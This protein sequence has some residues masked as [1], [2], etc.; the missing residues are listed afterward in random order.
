MIMKYVLIAIL[1]IAGMNSMA[2]NVKTLGAKGD[3]KQDD[4]PFI[5]AAIERALLL[6]EDLFLPAGVY[7]CDAFT[8]YDK[9]IKMNQYGTKKIKIYGEAGTKITTSKSSGC[10]FYIYYKSADVVIDKIFFENTH[11]ITDDQTNAIQLFGTAENAIENLT[12]QNC[13]F[14]GFS[15]AISAQGIQGLIIQNNIFESPKGHDNAQEGSAP[16]VYIWLADNLN[17]QCFDVIISNNTASGFSGT[18]ITKTYTKRP[19]DGFV[20][21]VGYRVTMDGNLTKHFGEEHML[22]QP[23]NTLIKSDYPILITRNKFYLKVPVG[24][25]KDGA[26][27]ISNCGVRADCNA[28]TIFDNDFF[29]Y[30]NAVLILP[31]DYPSLSQHSYNVSVNRFFSHATSIYHIREAIKIQ[32]SIINLTSNIKVSNNYILIKDLQLKSTRATIAIYNCESVSLDHNH[33]VGSNIN[34]AGFTLSGI[35]TTN[36]FKVQNLYNEVRI[37]K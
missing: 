14:E 7:K 32:G 36:C 20:Y 8:H 10:I 31:Y 33:I 12:I 6:G 29:D 24:S 30:T 35:T 2:I 15:T 13:R 34:E 4:A 17:G 19:M 16:A 25:M 37:E 1:F 27:L 22:F 26:P 18:D 5:N 3:G 11:G 28:V 23:H 9:L 21:G